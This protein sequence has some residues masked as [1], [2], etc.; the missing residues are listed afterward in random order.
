MN[1]TI[2]DQQVT[3][4][5]PTV[6][7]VLDDIQKALHEDCYYSHM[8]AD[9]KEIYEDCA[10]YLKGHLEEISDLVIKTK[11]LEFFIQDNLVL[12]KDYLDHAIPGTIRLADKFYQS[13]SSEDWKSLTDLLTGIQWLDQLV[14]TVSQAGKL[15]GNGSRYLAIRASLNEKLAGFEDA[16]KAQDN[17]LIADLVLYEVLPILK[18]LSG[19]IGQS[20]ELFGGKKS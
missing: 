8:I 14:T 7:Q 3:L 4:L 18:D 20:L 10:T 17:V 12:A 15:P 11:T 1:L 2:N 6:R 5:R 9:G 13:P 19:E 16:L